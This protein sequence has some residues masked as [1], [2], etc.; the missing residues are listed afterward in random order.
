MD[1]KK[2]EHYKGL[3]LQHKEKIMKN[4]ILNQKEDLH[5]AQEDL[6]D[7]GDL[8]SSVINQQVTFQLRAKEVETLRAIEFALQRVEEGDYGHCEDCGEEINEK[9]LNFQPWADMCITHAEEH[10][11]N[12]SR[13]V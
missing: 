10:E 5:V 8:A 1:K 11:K 3:L 9:R 4:G 7:E 2:L 6:A 12:K 13:A